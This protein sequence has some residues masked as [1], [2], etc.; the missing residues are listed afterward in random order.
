MA[1]SKIDGTNLIAP[2]IPVASGGTGSATLAGAGLANT[3]AFLAIRSSAAT[4]SDNT[5]TKIQFNTEKFDTDNCYDN[6]TNHR[7]N[8]GVA[9]KYKFFAQVGGYGQSGGVANTMAIRIGK[10]GTDE[11]ETRRTFDSAVIAEGGTTAITV[12]AILDSDTDDYFEVF[13]YINTNGGVD[14]TVDYNAT[15]L[16]TYFGAY[17]I[18]GA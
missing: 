4:V 12:E 18:I 1:L 8:P 2:T 15:K 5:W 6:S 3:P 9:G 13:W 16:Y 11:V 17:K 10:N 7:F 14:A